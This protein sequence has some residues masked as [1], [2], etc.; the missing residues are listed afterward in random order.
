[1]TFNQPAQFM[2][3]SYEYFSVHEK[4]KKNVFIGEQFDLIMTSYNISYNL[5]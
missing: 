5:K 1:M 2:I 3:F 4:K